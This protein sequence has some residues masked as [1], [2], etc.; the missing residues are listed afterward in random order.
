MKIKKQV[1]NNAVVV[2]A[3]SEVVTPTVEKSDR[4]IVT[5]INK[6][7]TLGD[8]GDFCRKRAGVGLCAIR[9]FH[10]HGEWEKRL[11]EL[12]PTRSLRTL[13]RYVKAG[14]EVC[15]RFEAS[16]HKIYDLLLHMDTERIRLQADIDAKDRK[17]LPVRGVSKDD[18]LSNRLFNYVVAITAGEKEQ[19]P[20]PKAQKLTPEQEAAERR[21]KVEGY[22]NALRN[23]SGDRK[24][25]KLLEADALETFAAELTLV[26]Q[27][28]RKELREREV[29]QA[30]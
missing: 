7:M 29:H 4:E 5:Q 10:N 28:I 14:E 24:T 26:V 16:P 1:K 13:N 20:T 30:K 15:R 22:A 17:L 21:G 9:A 23:W 8:L 18:A 3:K 25:L 6:D 11:M 12:F 2:A 27:V 19:A